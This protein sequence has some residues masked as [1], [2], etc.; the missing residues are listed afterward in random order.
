M[1]H[2]PVGR[3]DRRDEKD[4]QNE[5]RRKGERTDIVESVER[6]AELSGQIAVSQPHQTGLTR[7]CGQTFD[8]RGEDFH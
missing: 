3:T 4:H 7:R 1:G 8:F 6:A 5:D 2:E